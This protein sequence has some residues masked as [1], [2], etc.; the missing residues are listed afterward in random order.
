M[1]CVLSVGVP[2]NDEN[3]KSLYDVVKSKNVV[4]GELKVKTEGLSPESLEMIHMMLP[5]VTSPVVEEIGVCWWWGMT[6]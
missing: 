2:L 6:V 1:L 3:I 5:T 4:L